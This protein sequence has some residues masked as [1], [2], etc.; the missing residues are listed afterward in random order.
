MKVDSVIKKA[1]A[2]PV[3]AAELAAKAGRASAA[4]DRAPQVQGEA[5]H[6]LLKEFASTPEELGKLLADPSMPGGGPTLPATGTG[7]T[8]TI[9]I[10]T[11][12]TLPCG[13][14]TTTTTTGTLTTT[15]TLTV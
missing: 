4:F 3:Y 6:E 9:T 14:T 13:F 15:A 12:T 8:T 2:D 7:T 10:A 1:L 5:W 11:L